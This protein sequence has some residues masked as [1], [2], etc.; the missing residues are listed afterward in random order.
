LYLGLFLA[1]IANEKEEAVLSMEKVGN[2]D[3]SAKGA[4]KLVA[5][6]HFPWNTRFI[7]KKRVGIERVISNEIESAA[8]PLIGSRFDNFGDNAA[9]IPA[10]FGGVIVL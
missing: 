5:F 4:A 2:G 9:A 8:M 10:V 6:Q 3:R 7:I 1:L